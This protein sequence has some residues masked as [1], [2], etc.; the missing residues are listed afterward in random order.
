[1]AYGVLEVHVLRGE[2]QVK[3]ILCHAVNSIPCHYGNCSF[4][5]V[6]FILQDFDLVKVKGIVYIDT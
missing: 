5:H 1:M 3:V 6:C 2:F 4:F